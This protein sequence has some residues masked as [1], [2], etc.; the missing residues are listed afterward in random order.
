MYFQISNDVTFSIVPDTTTIYTQLPQLSNDRACRLLGGEAVVSS[1]R[2]QVSTRQ[3]PAA[4][5]FCV[6]KLA[7]KIVVRTLCSCC[8]HL[9][10]MV[11]SSGFTSS[12]GDLGII[13]LFF[14]QIT[15]FTS[16]SMH[17]PQ[18]QSTEASRQNSELFVTLA[19]QI[20]SS[21]SS[22]SSLLS[23]HFALVC[24]VSVPFHPE[25]G[26]NDG[27]YYTAL[28]YR[29]DEEGRLEDENTY[30]SRQSAFVALYARLMVSGSG[31]DWCM[32]ELWC[33]LAR[34][35]NQPPLPGLSATALHRVLSVAQ[36]HLLNHYRRQY[37]KLLRCL[38]S[39]QFHTTIFLESNRPFYSAER[40][41]V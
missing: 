33:W 35:L 31:G 38:P 14:C 13:H 1:G 2:Q 11:L 10:I 4:P 30:L 29:V 20:S 3:H 9:L 27:E 18:E 23:S 37:I 22:F 34:L 26:A 21:N 41:F 7:R 36:K 5:L 25:R 15:S 12:G 17:C 28:G 8:F 16:A 40:I 19:L 39:H 6:D 32:K 24:P